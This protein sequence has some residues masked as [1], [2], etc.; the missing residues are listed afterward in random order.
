MKFKNLLDFDVESF[1]QLQ[2]DKGGTF[3]SKRVAK[4]TT[5]LTKLLLERSSF[6]SKA[7]NPILKLSIK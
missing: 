1:N 6:G 7:F 4:V 5:S 2:L 3:G